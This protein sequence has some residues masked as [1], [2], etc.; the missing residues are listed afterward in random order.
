MI[1]FTPI[2]AGHMW[3][4]NPLPVQAEEHKALL[5]PIGAE[6]LE[7]S[8]GLT[9]WNGVHCL[10]CAGVYQIW[11]GRAEAWILLDKNAHKFIRPIVRHARYVL[12]TFPSRRIEIG[13]KAN[14]VEGHKLA[15]LLG[16]SNPAFLESFHP[17]GSNVMLYA[18]IRKD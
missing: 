10:G 2:R 14:N 17:D 5:G 9:A 13:V 4:I 11:P 6:I 8:M 18:R 12:D 7:K 16:F 1:K 15:R 3:C